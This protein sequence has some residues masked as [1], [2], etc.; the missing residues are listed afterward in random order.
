MKT[1]YL[2]VDF[3]KIVKYDFTS[4]EKINMEELLSTSN[5]PEEYKKFVLCHHRGFNVNFYGTIQLGDSHNIRFFE[6]L[7]NHP[8]N[9]DFDRKKNKMT[10]FSST[11]GG[12]LI[13]LDPRVK[14]LKQISEEQVVNFY[15][16]L[17]D[18]NLFESY[19]N[20]IYTVFTNAY[21]KSYPPISK[22]LSL[23]REKTK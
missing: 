4:N 17:Q 23:Y 9:L 11:F 15:K 2:L 1:E 10:F 16:T 14:G 3:D 21:D 19:T 8:F 22:K 12:Y 5:L 6:F 20:F 13:I 7:S 18:N